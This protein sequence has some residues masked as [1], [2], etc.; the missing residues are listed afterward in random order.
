MFGLYLR[1][2]VRAGAGQER[3]PADDA[4]GGA[5]RGRGSEGQREL[6]EEVGVRLGQVE[7]DRA[8]RVIGDDPGGQVAPL[9]VLAAR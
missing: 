2:H 5:G 1:D 6:V 9:R 8:R 7:G 4:V 3:R